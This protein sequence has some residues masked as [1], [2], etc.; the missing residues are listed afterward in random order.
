MDQN[1]LLGNNE[2]DDGQIYRLV[3]GS[4]LDQAIRN[5]RWLNMTDASRRRWLRLING[6]STTFVGTVLS[7]QR[8]QIEL[9][10]MIIVDP[11]RP[12]NRWC[13]QTMITLENFD[14]F[15]G[16]NPA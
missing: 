8:R 5:E 13:V 12:D 7:P 2:Y 4:T 15:T 10:V 14:R 9:S 3:P 11:N 6:P 16:P 1:R